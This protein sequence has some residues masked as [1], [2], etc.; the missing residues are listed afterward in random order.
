MTR[1]TRRRR[2]QFGSIRKLRSGRHQARYRAP[3]GEMLT[4]G[5][6]ATRTEADEAL[7]LVQ[8]SMATGTWHDR[9]KGERPLGDYAEDLVDSRTDL[10]PGTR[11]LYRRL[12]RE[13]VDA[14]LTVRGGRG[15]VRVINLGA[16][17]IGDLTPPDIREWHG[18]VHAEALRRAEARHRRAHTSQKRINQAIRSWAA[19]QRIAVKATGR[20]PA[21]VREAWERSGGPATMAPPALPPN[22]GET[23]TAHAYRFL[24]MVLAHATEDGLIPA[25]PCKVKNAGQADERARSERVP[26]TPSEIAVIAQHMPERYRAAVWVAAFSGLRAGELFALQ[27]KHFNPHTGE[28]RVVRALERSGTG[29]RFGPG[30]SRAAR[31]TVTI[32]EPALSH[33]IGH[34]QHFTQQTRTP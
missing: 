20:I 28:I 16:R 34:L 13:W 6:Y 25:N 1:T 24:R 22:A 17:R 33:L 5:T 19:E 8:A 18:A 4:L 26:A 31:R 3:D 21:A 30:K 15:Q 7:A 23:E 14:P 12:L 2:R 9:S 32:G 11:E 10:A 29:R 27:R